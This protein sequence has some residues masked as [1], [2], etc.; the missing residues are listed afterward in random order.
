MRKNEQDSNQHKTAKP[1]IGNKSPAAAKKRAPKKVKEIAPRPHMEQIPADNPNPPATPNKMEVHHHP[2]LEHKPK[3]W[4]EYLLEGFMI[5]IA[6]MMGFIAENIREVITNRE[7][8]RELTVQLARDLKNDIVAF[9]AARDGETRILASNDILINLLQQPLDKAD[10]KLIQKHIGV[11]HSL[12]PFH[13]SMGAI[14]AIKNELH[15]KQFSESDIIRYMS[16]YESRVELLRTVQNITLEYQRKYLDPFIV[17]HLAPD[18]INAALLHN[19]LTNAPLHNVTQAELSEL[20]AQTVLIR[21]NTNELVKD[22]QALVD[23]AQD[24]LKYISKQYGINE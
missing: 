24:M 17:A 11:S 9:K 12:F 1:G 23:E 8:A 13:P 21:I 18:N 15:L 14:N 19:P 22:N 3:P 10:G 7:H 4:K 6:V 2:Q 20:A 5:F 16:D